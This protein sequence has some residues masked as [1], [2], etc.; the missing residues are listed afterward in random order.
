MIQNFYLSSHG[1]TLLYHL[2]VDKDRTPPVYPIQGI[3]NGVQVEIHY[4]LKGGQMQ[5]VLAR[6]D[7]LSQST[8]RNQTNFDESIYH[9]YMIIHVKGEERRYNSKN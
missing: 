9:D 8:K 7:S 5:S 2:F 6:S 4:K 1:S 3:P